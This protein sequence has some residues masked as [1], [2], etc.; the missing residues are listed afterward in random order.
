MNNISQYRRALGRRESREPAP[1]TYLTSGLG[2]REGG[3]PR[4]EAGSL[5]RR[6]RRRRRRRGFI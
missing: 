2:R 4:P 6:R 5:K 1:R 3:Y